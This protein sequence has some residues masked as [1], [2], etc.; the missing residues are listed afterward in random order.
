MFGEILLN[1]DTGSNMSSST[2]Y[3]WF[4]QRLSAGVCRLPTTFRRRLH[5]RQLVIIFVIMI[6]L[7]HLLSTISN[8]KRPRRSIPQSVTSHFLFEGMH[9]NEYKNFTEHI[10][11]FN[12]SDAERI[13]LYTNL[14][15]KHHWKTNPQYLDSFRQELNAETNMS[16]DRDLILTQTNVKLNQE[17]LCYVV[18]K[19]TFWKQPNF[20]VTENFISTLPKES[21]FKG[22]R[23][24]KCAIVGNS[25]SL[26]NSKCG[27]QIDSMDF[28]FRCNGAPI[29]AFMQDAGKRTDFVTFN[30]SILFKNFGGL[31]N[32]S[33]IASYIDFMVQ[34]NSVIWYPCF[35]AR[36]LVEPCLKA[37]SYRDQIDSQLVIGHP[38]HY[39]SMWEFW[40]RR[41]LKKKPSTGF[42]LINVAATMC[43]EIHLYG[44]WP[45]PVELRERT[46]HQTAYHYFNEIPFTSHHNS[47][48]EFRILL[49]M[50]MLG[51]LNLHTGACTQ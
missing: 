4:A 7:L 25:G 24:Q 31:T 36:H 27:S 37:M 19:R 33:A 20:V 46:V 6:L 2:A 42:F 18:T 43:N 3:R 38:S 29:E 49:Q 51:T 9:G 30:P 48:G 28:V 35:G 50:H 10:W 17:L 8:T 47:D 34:Y 11:L 41:G 15:Q 16:T 45:F 32:E 5:S 23:Y 39:V 44:F 1:G 40:K 22:R 14:L 21:P 13:Y 12:N 26:Q